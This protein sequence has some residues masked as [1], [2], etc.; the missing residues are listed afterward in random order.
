V[1]DCK[2]KVCVPFGE[3]P[4]ISY[5]SQQEIIKRLE[6]QLAEK[7]K[8]ITSYKSHLDY[9]KKRNSSLIEEVSRLCKNLEKCKKREETLLKNT[10]WY[11]LD[12]D[13]GYYARRTLKEL[14]ELS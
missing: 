12:R 7:D 9:F 3:Q 6:S 5:L 13:V 10:E 8:E 1:S 11:A 14:E 4:E 2:C